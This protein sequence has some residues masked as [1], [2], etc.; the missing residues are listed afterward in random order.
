MRTE[1]KERGEMRKY[2]NTMIYVTITVFSFVGCRWSLV[3][4]W[5]CRIS[6]TCIRLPFF[7]TLFLY[8]ILPLS[9]IKQFSARRPMIKMRVITERFILLHWVILVNDLW[10]RMKF[11]TGCSFYDVTPNNNY[12]AFL[13]DE[14]KIVIDKR[15]SS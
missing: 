8:F 10:K 9:A 11:D 4:F 1:R 5:S 13:L 7:F 12:L 2:R 14:R 6:I 3:E 15:L